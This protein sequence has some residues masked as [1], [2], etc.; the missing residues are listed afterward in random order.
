MPV[1]VVAPGETLSTIAAQYG[2]SDYKRVYEHPDNQALRKKRPNPNILHPG[3]EVHIPD[4]KTKLQSVPKPK[5]KVTL[6]DD[7]GQPLANLP[8][9][10]TVGKVDI[11]GKTD[12]GGVVNQEI[13]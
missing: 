10:L 1:H 9:V 6:L 13:P 2:F 8:Y 4:V 3:D 11:E 5:L 12:G 7:L